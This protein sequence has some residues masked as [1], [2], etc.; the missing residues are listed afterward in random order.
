MKPRKASWRSLLTLNGGGAGAS[1]DRYRIL[2]RKIVVLMVSVSVVPLCLMAA[3][4]YYHYRDVLWNEVMDPLRALE[5]KTK[6]SLELFSAERVSTV[7][8]IASAYTYEQISDKKR[9]NRLFAHL[10]NEFEEFVDLGVIDADGKQVSYAGPYEL[11]GKDYSEQE[12][13]QEVMVK[14]VYFSDVFMGYRKFPHIAIAV[15]RMN[16]SG[17]AWIVRATINTT[18]FANLIASMGLPPESDA[19]LIN[20]DGILQ[21]SSKYFGHV[22]EKIS[23]PVPPIS[24]QPSV[25]RTTDPIGRKVVVVYSYLMKPDFVLIVVKPEGMIFRGWAGLR[26]EL[27]AVF[28]VSVV[29]IMAVVFRV[30]DGVIQRLGESDQE[31]EA[32]Y[33]E[34]EHQHKLSSIGRLAAGVAHE[35]NNPIAIIGEKAG[36]AQDLIASCPEFPK[37][38][39]FDK[40]MASIMQSVERCGTI[41]HRL[42]GFARRMD[43]Q[44]EQIDVGPLLQEVLGFL[45]KETVHRNIILKTDLPTDLPRIASDRGQL[46][47]VFLNL[48]NN[49]FAAV[50]DGGKVSISAKEKDVD[51][52]AVVIQDNG[53]G[54]TEET[55]KHIFEPFFTTRKGSGT[56]LG[57]SITYGIVKRLGGDIKVESQPGVGSRFTVYLPREA[58]PK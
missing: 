39:R 10:K 42:L 27:L 5:N 43:V 57:L 36:L 51:T 22:F 14:G 44:I 9:L 32:A 56:G 13:F 25:I 11:T 35:I 41:T 52:I 16:D 58:E 49:A 29:L 34:M 24:Y 55:L 30:T 6:H 17:Q 38:E 26:S 7:N 47:Q 8:F 21:T 2:K 54:M 3:I 20:R 19:F 12:W 23:M 4:D 48:I 40:L 45:G 18:K 37:R 1:P 33:R 53:V 50:E 28:I 31:R 46:Q 15:K